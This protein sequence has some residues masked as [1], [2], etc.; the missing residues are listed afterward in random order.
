MKPSRSRSAP[1][2]TDKIGGCEVEAV[3][4]VTNG[5][6]KLSE[7]R[8]GPDTALSVSVWTKFT[9]SEDDVT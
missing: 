7:P 6:S 5:A 9:E 2:R 1:G 3:T 8:A 4:E